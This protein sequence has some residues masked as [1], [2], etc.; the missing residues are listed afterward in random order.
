[1]KSYGEFLTTG[2]DRLFVAS[3]RRCIDHEVMPVRSWLDSDH[4]A[5]EIIDQG[6]VDMGSQRRGFAGRRVYRRSFP[7]AL[8][9]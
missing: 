1:M 6:R 8:R 4:G 3:I 2:E 7:T 9:V 5:F